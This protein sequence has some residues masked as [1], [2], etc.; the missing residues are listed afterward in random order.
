MKS[1]SK[2]NLYKTPCCTNGDAAPMVIHQLGIH[3][4]VLNTGK[5]VQSKKPTAYL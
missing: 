4:Q 3:T 1:V 2:I 5:Y